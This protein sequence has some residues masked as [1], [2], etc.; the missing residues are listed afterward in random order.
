MNLDFC[1]LCR[2]QRILNIN[3][4]ITDGVLDLAARK[5][6]LHSREVPGGLV[7][8]RSLGASSER[9]PLLRKRVAI[10]AAP[11]SLSVRQLKQVF[12]GH[13]EAHQQGHAHQAIGRN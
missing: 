9:V 2:S 5:K 11:S 4:Q 13:D 3:A 12:R 6:Y 8:D 7:D 10:D 1:F